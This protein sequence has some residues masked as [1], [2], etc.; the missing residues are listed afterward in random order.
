[1]D[2]DRQEY[3]LLDGTG[4]ATPSSITVTAVA[5]HFDAPAYSW[6]YWDW[7]AEEWAAF[8]PAETSAALHVTPGM[9]T[10]AYLAVRCAISDAA[11]P[12]EYSPVIGIYVVVRA[13]RELATEQQA[14]DG[15]DNETVMTPLRTAQAVEF[16]DGGTY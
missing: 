8:D 4:A 12:T 11:L 13:G 2:P 6:E 15:T 7:V 14:R 1:M 9:V 10:G 3:F 5:E 16:L